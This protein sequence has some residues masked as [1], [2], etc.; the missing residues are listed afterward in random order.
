MYGAVLR[1]LAERDP[2]RAAEVHEAEGPSGLT[3]STRMGPREGEAVDPGRVYRLRVTAYRPE[4]A[5]LLDPEGGCPVGER[6]ELEGVPFR[7]ERVIREGDPWAGWAT[8]EELIE[9]IR[10]RSPGRP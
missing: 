10:R 4:L 8:Y 9:R 6:I 3:C 7:V 1:R 2:A 5:P